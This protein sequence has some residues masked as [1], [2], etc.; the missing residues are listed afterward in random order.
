M[1]LEELLSKGSNER[2]AGQFENLLIE[3]LQLLAILHDVP[4]D[5]GEHP[6]AEFQTEAGPLRIS[7]EGEINPRKNSEYIYKR[8]NGAP[9]SAS[10]SYIDL[11]AE[12]TFPSCYTSLVL[13]LNHQYP[14]LAVTQKSY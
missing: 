4:R 3:Q 7:S 11:K 10:S 14:N 12:H 6:H 8:K 2:A 1:A 9:L 13:Y 5:R